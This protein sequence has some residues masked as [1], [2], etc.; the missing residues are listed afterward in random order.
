MSRKI[1]ACTVV[2]IVLFPPFFVRGA[3]ADFSAAEQELIKIE[4]DWGESYIKHDPSFAERI[5]TDDFTF[6]GSDGSI[7]EKSNYLI[8]IKGNTVFKQF[9]IDSMKIRIY[10]NTA[11]VIGL[12]RIIA[13]SG[14]S[15]V[16]GRYAFTDVFVKQTDQWKAVSG[17]VTAIEKN[18]P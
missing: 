2:A 18:Q 5:T 8:G 9:Q 17:H 13:K 11:V 1:F 3:D 4:N 12:A 6:V 10:G 15:E 7:V 14:Q 16:S